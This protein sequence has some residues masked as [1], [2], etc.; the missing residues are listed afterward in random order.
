[1]SP[2]KMQEQFNQM[3]M[4]P[5]EMVR[6]NSAVSVCLSLRL[7]LHLP[8]FLPVSSLS[9]SLEPLLVRLGCSVGWQD[10]ARPGT[11]T[12]HDKAVGSV[13]DRRVQQGPNGD[14]EV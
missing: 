4:D 5:S 7:R 1:M 3:G 2:E 8:R 10:H 11:G 13:R 9:L 12:A 14:H 6:F